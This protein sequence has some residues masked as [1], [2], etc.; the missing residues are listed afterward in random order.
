MKRY[1]LG[2][3]LFIAV[4]I[5]FIYF[6]L[7]NPITFTQIRQNPQKTMEKYVDTW[8]D[9]TIH[10]RMFEKK[11]YKLGDIVGTITIPS[12]DIYEMPIYYGTTNEN[13]NWQITTPGYEGNWQLFG[14]YGMAAVGAHNYQLFSKLPDVEIGEKFIV[15]T[16]D[17]TYVYEIQSEKVYD[18]TA[19]N[20]TDA[21]YTGGKPY[22]V[23]LL[24]CYPVGE[25]DTKDR[26][27]VYAT[28][29]KG[30]VFADENGKY[31]LEEEH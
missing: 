30:T 21:V 25:A 14:E 27:I 29:Q 15:E 12:I 4:N 6:A 11:N 10:K 19:G 16:A 31:Y 28:L 9:E 7:L 2:I 1:V 3:S 13:K 26:Y 17:D 18:H 5:I 24:T 22:S 8:N 20:W 23:S